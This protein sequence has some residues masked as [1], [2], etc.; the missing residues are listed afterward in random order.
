MDKTQWRKQYLKMRQSR[1][2]DEL[3]AASEQICRHLLELDEI[4]NSK[5][6]MLYISFNKEPDTHRL[7]EELLSLGKTV[8]APL[9]DPERLS[10]SAYRFDA[11]SSLIKGTYG[12]L[13]PKPE[14]PVP[15]ED[16]DCVLVPGCVFGRNFHRIGYGKGYYDRFLPQVPHAVKIGLCYDFCLAEQVEAGEYDVAVDLIVTDKGV[17]RQ[18]EY[19]VF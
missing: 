2:G 17:L 18:N 10:M 16:M 9:C 6:V 15:A 13:E 5:T 1:S 7:A 11:F 4:K 3:S 14:L 19:P 8:C 12:I